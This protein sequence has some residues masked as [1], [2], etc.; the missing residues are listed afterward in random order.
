MTRL[1]DIRLEL[2]GLP[3]IATVILW[4]VALLM[5]PAYACYSASAETPSDV[6]LKLVHVQVADS[7][8]LE[9]RWKPASAPFGPRRLSLS[10][11]HIH[12][13]QDSVILGERSTGIT[14]VAVG[15][16]VYD[17]VLIQMPALL[18]TI[19]VYA[20]VQAVDI[21]GQ[22]GPSEVSD[23]FNLV[24]TPLPPLPVDSVGVDT[25]PRLSAMVIWPD[26][27]TVYLGQTVQFCAFGRLTDGTAVIVGNSAPAPACDAQFEWFRD[28]DPSLTH[29]FKAL[30]YIAV[31]T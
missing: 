13:I 21:L 26:T 12:I 6:M 11:H 4:M 20:S 16:F 31:G 14:R 30:S 2:T 15:G 3:A 23:V 7:V 8:G 28:G 10:H 29:Y 19:Q 17:T 9:V 24:I 1:T 5:I 27:V 25:L 22:A 18:D